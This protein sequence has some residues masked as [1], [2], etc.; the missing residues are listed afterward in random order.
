MGR[1]SSDMRTV[2][3][4]A[5]IDEKASL[6]HIEHLTGIPGDQIDREVDGHAPNLRGKMLSFCLAFV[7]GTGFTLFG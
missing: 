1:S 3:E 6:K 7:A 5:T 2:D 4:A